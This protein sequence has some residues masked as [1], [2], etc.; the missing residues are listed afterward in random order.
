M[1]SRFRQMGQLIFCAGHSS[2]RLCAVVSSLAVIA[3]CTS[4]G[5]DLAPVS[6]RITLDG[7][8][9]AGGSIV[10]QPLAVPGSVNAGKGSGAYCDDDGR[11][12]LK[13]LDGRDG[14]VVGEHRVR[15]YGPRTQNAPAS[16]SDRG[17]LR[18][19]EIVPRKYNRET[20]LTLTVPA[21]GTTEANFQLTTK[22]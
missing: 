7:R 8:P 4:Q 2:R 18:V 10:C 16:D 6:G 15:I 14:A 20:E 5:R 22:K 19:P 13:T 12:Q 3:G 9:L 21:E 11:F 17:G 1:V